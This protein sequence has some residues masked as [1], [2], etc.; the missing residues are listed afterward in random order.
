MLRLDPYDPITVHAEPGP[1]PT[2]EVATATAPISVV[3]ADDHPLYRQGIIRALEADG[4]FLVIGDAGDGAAALWLIR[5]L[6]PD[7]ALLDV[8]M[9]ILDGVDVVNA[10]ALHGPD[11]PVA[12][13]SAFSDRPLV[14]SGAGGRRGGV[15]QQDRRPR[16]DLPAAGDHRRLARRAC[17]AASGPP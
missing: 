3:V 16:R 11:V 2:A 6:E 4:G 15:H 9:P 5:R 10:L 7:I 1:A 17:A 14:T 8:R 12:L 13:L